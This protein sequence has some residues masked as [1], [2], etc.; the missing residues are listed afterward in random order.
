MKIK[1]KIIKGMFQYSPEIIFTPG[2][3]IIGYDNLIYRVLS[4]VTGIEPSS[5]HSEYF[6]LYSTVE[7]ASFEDFLN[8]VTS[9]ETNNLDKVITLGTLKEILNYQTTGISYDGKITNTVLN[10][11]I[12]FTDFFGNLTKSVYTNSPLDIILETSELNSAYFKVDPEVIKNVLGTESAPNIDGIL[13][14]YTYVDNTNTEIQ[15]I[16]RIQELIE[17]ESGILLYRYSVSEEGGTFDKL[18][19]STWRGHFRNRGDVYINGGST[20]NVNSPNYNGSQEIELNN[21]GAWTEVIN[22]LEKIYNQT[23]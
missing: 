16:I 7:M 9:G 17:P 11:S 14:Q 18:N 8:S 15:N 12:T 21:S 13:R 10:D 5:S 19:T 22:G 2:D 20:Q 23:P 6:S 1:D 4:E 3:F